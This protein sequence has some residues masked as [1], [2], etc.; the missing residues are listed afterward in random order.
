M[1]R[2]SA[3]PELVFSLG[4]VG[5]VDDKLRIEDVVQ[6]QEYCLKCSGWGG[7]H[8]RF[9]HVAIVRHLHGWLRVTSFKSKKATVGRSLLWGVFC[10]VSGHSLVSGVAHSRERPRCSIAALQFFSRCFIFVV[11]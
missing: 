1:R 11:R 10:G 3:A 8:P 5:V 6:G 9:H 4:F 7:G 2:L